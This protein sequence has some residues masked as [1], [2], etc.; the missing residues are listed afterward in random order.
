MTISAIETRRHLF[1]LVTAGLAG[2]TDEDIENLVVQHALRLA[3]DSWTT[4]YT[5]A[6]IS[7]AS[8]ICGMIAGADKK[9]NWKT[10][11]IA[12]KMMGII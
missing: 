5:N 2:E 6:L 3:D 4:E 10:A 9:E 7:G 8:L 12:A 11:T 1:E